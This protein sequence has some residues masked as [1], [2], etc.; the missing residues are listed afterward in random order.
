MIPMLKE[1]GYE[2]I[3]DN[4]SYRIFDPNN[5]KYPGYKFTYPVID[6]STVFFNQRNQKVEYSN[7]IMREAFPN[8]WYYK[9]KFF[10]LQ[11][12]KFGPLEVYGP[13]DPGWYIKHYYGS[14]A[15]EQVVIYPRHFKP[16]HS[17]KITIPAEG[18]FLQPALPKEPLKERVK[19]LNF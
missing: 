4:S 5:P 11:K 6:I 16:K 12:Y 1:L 15:L 14:S 8:N 9:D 17:N 13:N 3:F 2:I 19:L 18:I 7:F 10:P